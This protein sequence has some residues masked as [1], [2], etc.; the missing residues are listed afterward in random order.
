[1]SRLKNGMKIYCIK[2]NHIGKIVK[3]GSRTSKVRV[4]IFGTGKYNV[5][6]IK[7]EYLEER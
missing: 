5:R 1:M 6:Q 3:L 4:P 7:N 2:S